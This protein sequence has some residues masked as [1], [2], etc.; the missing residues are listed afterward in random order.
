MIY[1]IVPPRRDA[2]RFSTELRGVEEVLD[3]G[4][5]AAINIPE[6]IKRRVDRG[7]VV[8]SPATI[9][10]E[11]Y[12]MLIRDRKEPIVNLIAPRLET[13]A[14]LSRVRKVLLDYKIP[15]LVL[16]GRERREDRLPGPDVIDALRMVSSE[17]GNSTLGGICIFSRESTGKDEKGKVRSISEAQRVWLKAGAGCDFVTSQ[18]CFESGPVLSFLASYQDLCERTGADPITVFVSLAT[19]PTRS[20]LALL[21]SLDVDVPQGVRKRLLESH[22]MGAESVKI[23]SEVFLQVV[24]SAEQNGIRVPLGLQIEQVGVNSGDLSLRLLDSAYPVIH[25]G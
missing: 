8:Y 10:P 6:L 23:A 19:V 22:D 11:E 12:A 5:I 13:D 15:N 25:P 1:E 24:T 9:P 2:S 3:E 4:R 20:I 18:I 14:L 21:D 7:G 16:V 17:K